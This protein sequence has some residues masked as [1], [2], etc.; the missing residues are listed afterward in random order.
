MV[1]GDIDADI[2][3]NFLENPEQGLRLLLKH[4]GPY[5]KAFLRKKYR[6]KL[7]DADFDEIILAAAFK[8][9]HNYESYDEEKGR[10]RTW[11]FSILK[12]AAIDFLREAKKR[13]ATYTVDKEIWDTF[14]VPSKHDEKSND[15]IST[16]PKEV[17]LAISE[18]FLLLNDNEQEVINYSFGANDFSPSE[19]SKYMNLASGYVRV[20]KNRAL[21][22]IKK[23]LHEKGF[24]P[25]AYRKLRSIGG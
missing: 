12:N 4:Y 6:G 3:L 21:G 23:H 2:Y 19:I 25:Q 14:S 22:K 9:Y 24:T 16:V 18:A 20:I 13:V 17:S 1:S 5:W 7:Q 10:F 11:A 8:I 15:E